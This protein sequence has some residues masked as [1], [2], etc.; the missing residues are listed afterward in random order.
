MTD[1]KSISVP[2]QLIR[3]WLDTLHDEIL[4][5]G[6]QQGLV[7]MYDSMSGL[8]QKHNGDKNE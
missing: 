8:Y 2:V 3:Y 7:N 6:T 5:K 1:E 4:G